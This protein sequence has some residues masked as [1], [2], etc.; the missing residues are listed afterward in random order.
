VIKRTTA[1]H[2]AQAIDPIDRINMQVWHATGIANLMRGAILSS[3]PVAFSD[4]AASA[5]HIASI[6]VDVKQLANVLWDELNDCQR[7]LLERGVV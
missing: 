2:A 5:D 1:A 4:F 7:K 3:E 6:L